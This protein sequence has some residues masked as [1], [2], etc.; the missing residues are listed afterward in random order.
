M[1][2]GWTLVLPFG[3]NEPTPLS[4]ET[5]ETVGFVVQVSVD[6][7]PEVMVGGEAVNEAMQ[8]PPTSMVSENVP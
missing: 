6:D 3:P 8:P 1:V 4:I 5:A 2:V 7:C